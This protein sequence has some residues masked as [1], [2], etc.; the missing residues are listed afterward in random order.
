MTTL[1]YLVFTFLACVL[2][3]GLG[4]GLHYLSKLLRIS[5]EPLAPTSEQ[6]AN[7]D[8]TYELLSQWQAQNN[9]RF[10]LHMGVCACLPIIGAVAAFGNRSDVVSTICSSI[11]PIAGQSPLCF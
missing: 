11:A 10:A 3:L 4:L 2:G 9:R 6:P 8:A 1:A 5:P 7:E